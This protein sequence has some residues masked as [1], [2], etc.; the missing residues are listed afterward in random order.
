MKQPGAISAR[1]K[2]EF[3]FNR[4]LARI[5]LTN[6]VAMGGQGFEIGADGKSVDPE[7]RPIDASARNAKFFLSV[8]H[9]SV[10]PQ[11]LKDA[12][13]EDGVQRY[14]ED[15]FAGFSLFVSRKNKQLATSLQCAT[16][17]GK[18]MIEAGFK[19]SSHHAEK[20]AGEGREWADKADGVMYYDN[21]IVLK[22]AKMPA[23]LLE[24][25][26]IV[27]RDEEKRMEDPA[28][29]SRIASAVALGLKNC[30]MLR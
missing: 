10:Q 9:D 6:I 18:K 2:S 25:G 5:I 22:N 29:R 1:G 30:G 3:E 28:V 12:T 16:A 20:I 11:Y 24:S 8:H 21:L 19:P 14:A 7:T 26:V 15:R 23:V 4:D 17:I 13:G 27:N